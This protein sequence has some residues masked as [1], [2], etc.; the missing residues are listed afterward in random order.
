MKSILFSFFSKRSVLLGAESITQLTDYSRNMQPPPKSKAS[1]QRSQRKKGYDFGDVR[2]GPALRDVIDLALD[3]H[4]EGLLGIGP[5]VL[6]E[7]LLGDLPE[8]HG[9]R[10]RLRLGSSLGRGGGGGGPAK[11][12]DT[13]WYTAAAAATAV[14]N[15]AGDSPVYATIACFSVSHSSATAAAIARRRRAPP[16]PPLASSGLG[17]LGMR[18]ILVFSQLRGLDEGGGERGEEISGVFIY[19]AALARERW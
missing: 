5:V 6:A 16:P 2:N 19:S 1:S 11:I 12:P 7:L 10:E 13:T 14:K 8:L 3:G 4:E 17:L 15:A 9:R 18:G